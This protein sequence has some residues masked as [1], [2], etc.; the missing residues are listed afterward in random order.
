MSPG[1]LCLLDRV[2]SD[3]A[4]IVF[5]LDLEPIVGQDALAQLQDFRERA[6]AQPVIDVCA[7]VSLKHHRFALSGDATAIDEILHDMSYFGEVGM[8]GDKVAVGQDKTRPGVGI[9][10]ENG[11]KMR[12]FHAGSIFP[13][14]NIVK[15][16]RAARMPGASS[17]ACIHR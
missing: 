9:L 17:L 8:G 14:R 13:F 12:E 1:E 15:P 5:D 6:G 7:D 16:P 11:A 10:F 4:A 2:L 3:D